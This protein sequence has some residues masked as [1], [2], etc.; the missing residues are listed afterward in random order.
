[1]QLPTVDHMTKT[2]TFFS[3]SNG[4]YSLNIH[5]ISECLNCLCMSKITLG[6][7]LAYYRWD[8]TKYATTYSFYILLI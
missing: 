3:A 6:L 4:S 7:M 8:T 1:M 5:H 2:A